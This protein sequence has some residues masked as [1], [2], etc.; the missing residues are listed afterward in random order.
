MFHGLD[1]Y[2]KYCCK[3]Q[4]KFSPSSLIGR[5]CGKQQSVDEYQDVEKQSR[6]CPF[7]PMLRLTCKDAASYV[8]S[9]SLVRLHDLLLSILFTLFATILASLNVDLAD[10]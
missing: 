10:F 3:Q 6:L 2:H 5:I 7:C 9:V 1:T 4:G 8:S